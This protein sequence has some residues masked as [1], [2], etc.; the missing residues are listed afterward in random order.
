MKPRTHLF[1]NRELLVHSFLRDS[2]VGH[3]EEAYTW[4]K[5]KRK[6][7]KNEWGGLKERVVIRRRRSRKRTEKETH[8]QSGLHPMDT[9]EKGE[10]ERE[11]G[12]EKK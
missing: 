1:S 2:E 11:K 10:G 12:E 3:V 8:Q 7:V 6:R 9:K 5:D 4:S